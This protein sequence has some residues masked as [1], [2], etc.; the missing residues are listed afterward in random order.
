MKLDVCLR[1]ETI[2]HTFCRL[3]F[4]SVENGN[5]IKNGILSEVVCILSEFQNFQEAHKVL[6]CCQRKVA[7][8]DV[9][10]KKKK[11]MR[12]SWKTLE[13]S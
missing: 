3:V 1:L 13:F 4:F 12:D 6:F 8:I 10:Q 9:Q 7:N 5:G 11:P 2:F